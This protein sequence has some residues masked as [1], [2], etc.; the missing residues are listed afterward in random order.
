MQ[1][2]TINNFENTLIKLKIKKGD[3]IFIFPELF[4]LGKLEG[5]YDS[6]TYYSTILNSIKKIIGSNGTIFLNTYTFDNSRQNKNFI[7]ESKNSTSGALSNFILKKKIIRSNHPLFSVA[8]LGKKSREICKNN[9]THNYG[10]LS[11]YYKM[12]HIKTKILCLGPE[13]S[14][15]PF[16]HT[17]EYFVGVPYN[18]NKIFKKKVIQNKKVINKKF[19]SF[20]RYLNLNLE[21]DYKKI[22]KKLKSDKIIKQKKIGSGYITV[23]DSSNFFDYVCKILTKNLHGLLKKNPNYNLKKYPYY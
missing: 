2:F 16:T 15:N 23:G 6:Q 19:I 10:Y 14:R 21:Y 1:N 3:N 7:N 9:S 17:A 11:P 4:R 13:F 8:G 5:V 22:D 20:V 12:M 18:Y